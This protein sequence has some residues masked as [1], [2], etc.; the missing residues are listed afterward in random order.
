MDVLWENL[1]YTFGELF[2]KRAVTFAAS[3]VLVGACF[4][5]ILGIKQG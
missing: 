5:A 4:G 2:K 3:L 1:G